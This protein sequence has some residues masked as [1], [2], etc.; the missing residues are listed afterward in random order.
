VRGA[1]KVMT[2]LMF[3]LIAITAT[4]LKQICYKTSAVAKPPAG[5]S[6]IQKKDIMYFTQCPLPLNSYLFFIMNLAPVSLTEW[7]HDVV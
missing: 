3:G 2:H 5:D 7:K 6:H 1:A 4:Q